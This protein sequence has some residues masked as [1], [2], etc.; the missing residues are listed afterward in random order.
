MDNWYFKI[1]L[2]RWNILGNL[3]CLHWRLFYI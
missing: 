3:L 2:Y 1:K